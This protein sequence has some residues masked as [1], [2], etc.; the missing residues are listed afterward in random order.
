MEEES[1]ISLLIDRVWGR[2]QQ[3]QFPK[4]LEI[5]QNLNASMMY[6]LTIPGEI[7][8]VFVTDKGNIYIESLKMESNLNYLLIYSENSGELIANVTYT[9]RIVFYGFEGVFIFNSV[10]KLYY[11]IDVVRPIY[12]INQ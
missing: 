8:S 6:N 4:W 1:E 2:V 11:K 5:I 12:L 9:G 3:K 7:V 10:E